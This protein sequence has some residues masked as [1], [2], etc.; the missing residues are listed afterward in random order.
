MPDFACCIQA[1][2]K[3]LLGGKPALQDLI[4]LE[5]ESIALAVPLPEMD[6]VRG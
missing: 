3:E 4:H 1:R 6:A 2:C 5:G